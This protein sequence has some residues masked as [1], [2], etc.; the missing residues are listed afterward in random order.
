MEALIKRLLLVLLSDNIDFK[1]G[2]NIRNERSFVMM[3]KSF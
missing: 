2:S 3:K 1:A